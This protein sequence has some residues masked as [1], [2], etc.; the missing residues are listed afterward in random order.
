MKE[1]GTVNGGAEIGR[2]Y[3]RALQVFQSQVA[4]YEFIIDSLRTDIDD[5]AMR[6]V[7]EN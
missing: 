1:G 4:V 7:R 6:E 5:L 2:V 3:A